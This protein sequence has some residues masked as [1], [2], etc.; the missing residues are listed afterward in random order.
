VFRKF[1]VFALGLGALAQ[2]PVAA[3]ETGPAEQLRRGD[4]V[5]VVLRSGAEYHL[6]LTALCPEAVVGLSG[7]TSVRVQREQLASL[8][9]EAQPFAVAAVP[10]P[11]GAAMTMLSLTA[12]T[13]SAAQ[14]YGTGRACGQLGIGSR[15]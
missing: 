4:F 5:H 15:C 14:H 6:K 10:H 1:C 3:D 9:R 7:N 12:M 8:E 13:R 11:E 2:Y